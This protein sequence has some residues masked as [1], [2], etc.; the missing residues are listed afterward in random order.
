V[1]TGLQSHVVADSLRVFPTLRGRP[2]QGRQVD[3]RGHAAIRVVDPRLQVEERK[4][5]RR[6]PI[7]GVRVRS[8]DHR[9]ERGRPT[10]ARKEATNVREVRVRSS[11]ELGNTAVEAPR[12]AG[13]PNLLESARFEGRLHKPIG[14]FGDADMLSGYRRWQGGERRLNDR[15]KKRVSR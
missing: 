6:G 3:V 7:D 12:G 9:Y 13:E 1:L 11:R 4:R 8:V 14:I 2:A 10:R 15:A 5:R